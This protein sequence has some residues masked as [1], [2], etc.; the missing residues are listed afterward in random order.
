[1]TA[2]PDTRALTEVFPAPTYLA[3]HETVIAVLGYW[4]SFHD[5]PV[6]RFHQEEDRIVLVVEGWNMD[7][8]LD[9]AGYFIRSRRHEVGFAFHGVSRTVLSGFTPENTL[10]GLMF[11]EPAAFRREGTFHV[12]MDSVLG[13]EFSGGF[14]A[15]EGRVT[16][17]TPLED[18]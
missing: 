11:S 16:H 7:G 2:T 1:M 15:V 3:N 6:I 14:R 18:R 10:F 4:P 8:G 13:P 5:S 9:E 12:E 17:V